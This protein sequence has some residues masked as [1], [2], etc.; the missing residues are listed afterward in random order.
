VEPELAALMLRPAFPALSLARTGGLLLAGGR[1]R[2]FGAEKAVARFRGRAMM[3]H[4]LALLSACAARAVSAP[5]SAAASVRACDLG[6][7]IVSDEVGAPSGPLA[8]V[9][10][11]LAWAQRSGL[12]ALVTLPCD[13]PLL[14]PDIVERL[15]AAVGEAPAAFAAVEADDFPLCAVWRVSLAAPLRTALAGDAHPS[16][17]G[18]LI[19]HGARRVAFTEADR[20][21]NANHAAALAQLERG[22]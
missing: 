7:D 4:G 11:G 10:A 20:F 17:R 14:P 12:D 9:N 8:G 22:A 5:L 13:M 1:S 19:E 2:R 6:L 15:A 21:V 16:V 3:E 18:W